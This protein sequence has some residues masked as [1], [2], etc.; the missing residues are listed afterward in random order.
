MVE[1]QFQRLFRLSRIVAAELIEEMLAGNPSLNAYRYSNAIPFQTRFLAVLNFFANGSYQKPTAENRWFSQS[2]SS[3]SVSLHIV[4]NEMMKLRKK[5]IRFPS[6]PQ[7]ISRVKLNFLE[8]L[9]MSGILCAIDGT[10]VAIIKPPEAENGYVYYN[11]KHFYSIN[12][13]AACDA[14]MKFVFVDAQYPGSV[15]DSAVWQMARLESL[16]KDDGSTF[17]L[18]D[19]GYPSTNT[20]LTPVDRPTPDSSEERYN[21][22]HKHTRNIIER[23]FGLLKMRFR[24]VYHHRVL[25]YSPATAGKIFYACVIL[26]NIC[27]EKNLPTPFDDGECEDDNNHVADEEGGDLVATARARHVR[28]AYINR[29]YARRN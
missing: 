13:L 10:H 17:I 27:I 25:H 29:F 23:A 1:T 3:M 7:E 20:I 21:N 24:C 2:Q 14:D 4:L 28:Q 5:Y 22:A 15:H 11:R 6:T 8:K 26:H 19:S 16:I 9:G 18:G 12:A